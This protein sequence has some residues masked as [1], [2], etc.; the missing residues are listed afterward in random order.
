LP[1][2]NEVAHVSDLAFR[3]SDGESY[4]LGAIILVNN[5]SHREFAK[6]WYLQNTN[7]FGY[8]ICQEAGTDAELPYE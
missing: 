8:K 2:L 1:Y 6:F 5:E 4:L 3:P 7:S